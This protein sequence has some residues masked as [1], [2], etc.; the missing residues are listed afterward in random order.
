MASALSPKSQSR[1]A[2]GADCSTDSTAG[3]RWKL[4]G[5][6]ILS[7]VIL[8]CTLNSAVGGDS[9]EPEQSQHRSETQPFLVDEY[10]YPIV[11][12]G[13]I[14]LALFNKSVAS[15]REGKTLMFMH[16]PKTGGTTM[17]EVARKHG[18]YWLT[19]LFKLRLIDF[20]SSLC[21]S[22]EYP[23]CAKRIQHGSPQGACPMWHVP[24]RWWTEWFLQNAPKQTANTLQWYFDPAHTD[25]FCIVR[26]PFYKMVSEYKWRAKPKP[27]ESGWSGWSCTAEDMNEWISLNLGRNFDN[28]LTPYTEYV[29]DS[30]GNQIIQHV[31]HY[32][33]QT[34][35]LR[36]LFSAYNLDSLYREW[37]GT[38]SNRGQ[39]T[40]LSPTMISKQNKHIIREQ[41]E[42]D[43][44]I[45]G[46]STDI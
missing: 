16:I 26:N 46:Y 13:S 30:S 23:L 45:F 19:A 42:E 28:H 20:N 33:N 44:R 31:V 5:L 41:Y 1:N 22:R 12:L 38:H 11:D 17:A 15:N 4:I 43:F 25:W 3:I 27:P 40:N 32:E 10:S 7:V 24:L 21:D 18:I 36:Q 34:E 39:C 6:S 8:C 29:F 35:Q 37:L 14:N 2:I 9:V